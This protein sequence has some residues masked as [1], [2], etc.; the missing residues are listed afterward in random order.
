MKDK[1]QGIKSV[2]TGAVLGDYLMMTIMVAAGIVI[3]LAIFGVSLDDVW[4][5]SIGQLDRSVSGVTGGESTYNAAYYPAAPAP[6]APTGG[7][8]SPGV[9]TLSWQGNVSSDGVDRYRVTVQ[10]YV[11]LKVISFWI[12]AGTRQVRCNL[13]IGCTSAN[14]AVPLAGQY[15]WKVQ[16]HNGKGWGRSAGYNYITA[17]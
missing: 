17:K 2:E 7:T 5:M 12:P 10:R 13:G 15:R 16:A 3:T 1:G 6:V 11:N 9:N 4:N 14:V 8:V